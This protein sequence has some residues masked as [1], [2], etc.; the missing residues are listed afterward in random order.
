MC[1]GATL[2]EFCPYSRSYQPLRL[3]GRAGGRRLQGL[4]VHDRTRRDE[5][6]RADSHADATGESWHT[7]EPPGCPDSRRPRIPRRGPRSR[8]EPSPTE[9]PRCRT[10]TLRTKHSRCGSTIT[11]RSGHRI[12]SPVPSKCGARQTSETLLMNQATTQSRSDLCIGN[13]SAHLS[14]WIGRI[15]PPPVTYGFRR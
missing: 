5:P 8:L 15:L 2:N 14:V 13:R 6:S 9:S 1:N 3:G 12:R 4:V 11:A 7:P 10:A